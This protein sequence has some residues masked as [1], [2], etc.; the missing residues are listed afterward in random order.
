[1]EAEYLDWALDAF[2]G[3]VAV[4]ELYEGPYCVLSAV[5]NRRY[6]RILYEV[7]DHDPTHDDIEAFLWRLKTAL[8]RPRP[9]AGRHHHRRF[10]AVSRP[11]R[12]CL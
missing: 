8:F 10:L 12:A 5:D 2:S 6:K 1:M 9:D 11:D 4:D 7:L 3:Y